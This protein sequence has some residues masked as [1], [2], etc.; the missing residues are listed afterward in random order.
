MPG[1]N[2]TGPMGA[3]P[4]TG[5]RRGNC[6]PVNRESANDFSNTGG[7]GRRMGSG[8]GF[9]CGPGM[10][11]GR[12]F[13]NKRGWG[14]QPYGFRRE[15]ELTLLKDQAEYAKKTVETINNRIS[16]LEK[17]IRLQG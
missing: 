8:R 16:E 10:G 7:F 17:D 13:R 15:D 12:G 11:M 2:R 6:N 5:G 9:R 14:T 1:L 3:G 4:M